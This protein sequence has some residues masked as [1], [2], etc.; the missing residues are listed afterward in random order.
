MMDGRFDQQL[1]ELFAASRADEG[2]NNGSASLWPLVAA[3]IF[4]VVVFANSVVMG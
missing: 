1:A 4:G 2:K 3:Y